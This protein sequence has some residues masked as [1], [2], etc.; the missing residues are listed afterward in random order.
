LD[1]YRRGL[2]EG[3]STAGIETTAII[4]HEN[5]IDAI[6]KRFI[7]FAEASNHEINKVIDVSVSFLFLINSFHLLLC[8]LLS[9]SK[10]I[11]N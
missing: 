8:M 7:E 11:I 2:S 9:D 1:H 4:L 6:F 5:A 3:R 10:K